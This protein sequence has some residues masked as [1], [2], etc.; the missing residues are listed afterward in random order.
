[1]NNTTLSRRERKKQE[2]QQHIL[3]AALNLFE[4]QGVEATTIDA[5]AEAADVSRGTFFNYFPTKESLLNTIA[6]EELRALQR[7]GVA[8][9]AAG[10]V[11]RIYALMRTLMTDSLAFLQV[12]RYILL[13]AM[14]HPTGATSPSAHLDALLKPLV[15]QAQAQGEIRSALDPTAVTGALV[16]VY[17]GAF[18]R[19]IAEDAVVDQSVLAAVE[20]TLDMLFAGIAGP[21]FNQQI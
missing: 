17:L 18:F 13:D 19:L 6:A 7:R 5:I 4:T 2:N 14:L 3:E 21:E 12:T 8:D 15:Q 9:S 11:A 1:M 10:P 20:A 16:G